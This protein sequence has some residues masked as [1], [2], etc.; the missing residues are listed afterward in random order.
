MRIIPTGFKRKMEETQHK[1]KCPM[2]AGIICI[3]KTQGHTV[4]VNVWLNVEL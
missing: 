4:N 1:Y 3:N 2:L